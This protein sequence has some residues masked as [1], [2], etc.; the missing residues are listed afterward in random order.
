MSGPACTPTAHAYT[1][2]DRRAHADLP[3]RFAALAARPIRALAVPIL[4]AALPTQA[5]P[6][7]A[8]A[9]CRALVAHVT[10]PLL[11]LHRHQLFDRGRLLF[12]P[13]HLLKCDAAALLLLQALL[14][15]HKQPRPKRWGGRRDQLPGRYAGRQ[16]F[17][18][19]AQ[20]NRQ[21]RSLNPQ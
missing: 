20:V 6:V 14:P 5:L 10:R 18:L 2:S 9:A 1:L 13:L 7:A 21:G 16:P 19:L 17:A 11:P 4:L 12:L 15:F 3:P 8:R